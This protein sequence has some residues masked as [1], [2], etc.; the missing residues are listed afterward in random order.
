M[1]FALIGVQ[2]K[3]GHQSLHLCDVKHEVKNFVH[4]E[5]QDYG[6]THELAENAAT[7]RQ[8]WPPNCPHR[9]ER[10]VDRSGK[11]MRAMGTQP[12]VSDAIAIRASTSVK[13]DLDT[14]LTEV[15]VIIER[16]FAKHC[17]KHPE[18]KETT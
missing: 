15:P 8:S 13:D 5:P 17:P 12:T 14:H 10:P 4:V 16:A 18:P 11:S 9:T 6:S 3:A 1:L 2:I 7:G